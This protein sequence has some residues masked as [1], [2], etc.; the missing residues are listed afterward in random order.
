MFRTMFDDQMSFYELLTRM[1]LCA[2]KESAMSSQEVFAVFSVLGFR[3]D[4]YQPVTHMHLMEKSFLFAV[5]VEIT[6]LD[7]GLTS[8]N[9][10][11][12]FSCDSGSSTV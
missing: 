1:P 5:V 4:V 10:Y 9:K 3:N 12:S 7:S 2:N 8:D 6:V 11:C